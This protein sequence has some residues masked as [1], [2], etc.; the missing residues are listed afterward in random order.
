MVHLPA[1]AR[2]SKF[3]RLLRKWISHPSRSAVAGERLSPPPGWSPPRKTLMIV[4]TPRAGTQFLCQLLR[5]TGVCGYPDEFFNPG[6]AKKYIPGNEHDV[7]ARLLLP[8][9]F[10]ATPNDVASVKFF[11][12]SFDIISQ[13]A[14]LFDFYPTPQFLYISRQDKLAQAI[15]LARARQTGKWTA[16]HADR[17]PPSYSSKLIYHCLRKIC[18]DT[19]RFDMYFSRNGITPIRLTYEQIVSNPKHII[20]MIVSALDVEWNNGLNT[21]EYS[22]KIQRDPT[23][24]EWRNRFIS[25]NRD[26]SWLDVLKKKKK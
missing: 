15:S 21:I 8:K 19:A 3:R 18:I 2:S 11:A 25:E 6:I 23:S 14:N 17:Q 24:I 16:D 22:Q 12:A 1:R 13:H 10:G 7:I 5:Q 4:G 20:S 26:M 9:Q